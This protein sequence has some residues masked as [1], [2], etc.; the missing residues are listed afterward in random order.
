[1]EA[2][3]VTIILEECEQGDWEQVSSK[4]ASIEI[5]AMPDADRRARARLLLPEK[6]AVLELSEAIFARGK[7]LESLGFKAAD[8]VHVAAAEAWTAD[9]FLSCDDRMCRLARRRRA[10]LDVQVANPLGWLK[11]IGHEIDA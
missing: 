9:V 7:V 10:E 4:M 3:A 5:D 6:G 11:E 8:A 1:L 2:E